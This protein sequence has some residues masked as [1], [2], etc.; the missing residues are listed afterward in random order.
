[1]LFP[2]PQYHQHVDL[3]ICSASEE[4]SSLIGF[5]RRTILFPRPLANLSCI[6]ILQHIQ[7]VKNIPASHLVSSLVYLDY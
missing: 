7:L 4:A 5:E 3:S 1:M 6:L 2:P